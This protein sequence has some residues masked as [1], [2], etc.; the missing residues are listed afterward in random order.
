LIRLEAEISGGL[1]PVEPD[2]MSAEIQERLVSSLS[3]FMAVSLW[4]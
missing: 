2:G 4:G 1:F 3:G